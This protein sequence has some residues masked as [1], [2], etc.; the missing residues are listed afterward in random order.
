MSRLSDMSDSNAIANV[1][2]LN[3]GESRSYRDALL[4]WMLMSNTLSRESIG[5]LERVDYG[6][7]RGCLRLLPLSTESVALQLSLHSKHCR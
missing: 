4:N 6:N 1:E 3:N 7:S 2:S 5:G